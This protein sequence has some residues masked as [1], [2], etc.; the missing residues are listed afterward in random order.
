MMR[1]L[2]LTSVLIGFTTLAVLGARPAT[3][4]LTNGERVSGELTYK[5]GSD[6][7]LNG[8]DYPSSQVAIISFQPGDPTAAELSQLPHTDNPADEHE[9][10]M[11]VT[12][13]GQVIHAKLYHISPDGETISFD[14]LGGNSVAARRDLPASQI[15]RIYIT[16]TSARSIYSNVLNAPA[17]AAA[18]VAVATS[19]VATNGAILVNANQP[20]TDT[21]ITVKKGDRVSFH[22]NGQIK[23]T[24][25]GSADSV[26]GADGSGGFQGSRARYPVPAMPVGGLIFKVGNGA[27]SPI[28]SN[29]QPITMPA[30]GRLYLGVNDDE[31][32][33]NSGAFAVT[34]VK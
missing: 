7:T 10:H 34:I 18:P 22:T 31:F 20:W 15:A 13:G 4:V 25:D 9:R 12:T 5:G 3:F 1:R 17:V 28:G 19:G 33:D 32:G 6:F 29:M 16:P 23:V 2:A 14:P 27:P 11:I 21:G 8:R 30:A 24:T 26:A